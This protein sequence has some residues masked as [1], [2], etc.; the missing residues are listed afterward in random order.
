MDIKKELPEIFSSFS[1]AR[2][3]GFIKAKE[4]KE[5]NRPLIGTFCSYMPQEI[6]MAAGASVVSLCSTSDET[7]EEAENYLPRN[8]CPLIKSSYGFAKT[9]KCPYFYF[10]DLIVGET[11]CDG[12]KKMYEYLGE[13]KPV[14]VMQLPNT[15]I[16]ENSFKLWRDEIIRLKHKIEEMFDIEIKE[17]DIKQAILLKNRERQAIKDFYSLGKL[18]PSAL[19]GMDI[20]NVV[21]GAT[22]KFDKEESIDEIS[23]LTEKIKRSYMEGK[24]LPQKPRILITGCPIGGAADKVVKAVEKNG[25]YVVAFENCTVSKANELLVDENKDVFDALTEKYLAIGCSCMTPNKNRLETLKDMMREY[26]V[27]GV[28]DVILQACHTYAVESFSIKRFVNS[29]GIP[30][31]PVEIDYS[32]SNL[33]QLSTRIGAFIEML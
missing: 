11:T 17:E 21:H 8:L 22:F 12:K 14:H 3:N 25:A 7:I 29:S 16:G 15:Q 32:Q 26:K 33:G 9:D 23:Y 2:K 31:M 4:L 19:T 10:S 20:L 24:K 6:A 18:K 27:D 13:F 30:Y 28:I 5:K 1:E